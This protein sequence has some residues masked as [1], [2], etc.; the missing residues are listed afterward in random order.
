MDSMW[1]YML[2]LFTEPRKRIKLLLQLF[3][4]PI[5]VEVLE[6]IGLAGSISQ[7]DI[8]NTLKHH[9]NKTIIAILKKLVDAGVLEE[10]TIRKR[11]GL[12]TVWTKQ[13]KLTNLGKWFYTL[14]VDPSRIP[15]GELKELATSIYESLG[16]GMYD[17][18]KYLNYDP[19]ENFR[20]TLYGLAKYLISKNSD[21]KKKEVL[22]AGGL[23]LDHHFKLLS[24]EL[25]Y[26]KSLLG[27][28]GAIMSMIM[29]KLKLGATLLTEA[30]CDLW[31]LK[32]L[33]ELSESDVILNN[34]KLS[35][36]KNIAENII[37]YSNN[38]DELRIYKV[39][40]E[41]RA[42]SPNINEVNWLNLYDLKAY[43]AGITFIEIAYKISELAYTSNSLFIYRPTLESM[44]RNLGLFKKILEKKP[45]LII[46]KNTYNKLYGKTG[47][48]CSDLI[49]LGAKTLILI[50]S[51]IH[52]IIFTSKCKRIE[53]KVKGIKMRQLINT[54]NTFTSFFIY[55]TLK[56]EDYLSS[57]KKSLI[58]S[59][60]TS[61]KS[62]PYTFPSTNEVEEC[63]LKVEE[64]IER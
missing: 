16:R 41:S 31:S 4:S 23:S 61:A 49:G 37:V 22:V 8:I 35:K 42:T 28:D 19:I 39:V 12:R 50:I 55:Y 34:V 53:L 1:P 60:I 9:S 3:S 18:A 13:Y 40:N 11:S 62:M 64:N 26:L 5:A 59:S 48:G 10:S 24:D 30:A 46:S 38:G 14:I 47:I 21:I 56:E 25:Q 2:P 27:G 36:D 63:N 6:T 20:H 7:K 32:W 52:A 45:I 43:Y 58:A 57:A 15:K 54:V 33:I 29:S 17:V 51:P 44:I